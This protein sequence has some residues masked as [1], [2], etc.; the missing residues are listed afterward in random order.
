MNFHRRW[1]WWD[2]IQAIFLHLFYFK[3]IL[4]AIFLSFNFSFLGQNCIFYL[5]LALDGVQCFYQI[6]INFL[7]S[8]FQ[9]IESRGWFF[10]LSKTHLKLRHEH[11]ISMT[12]EQILN[13]NSAQLQRN[14][15]DL[16]LLFL[17]IFG[18]LEKLQSFEFVYS[19]KKI[20]YTL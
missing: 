12:F 14:K 6:L 13:P 19:F 15:L 7:C 3:R 11:F 16:S 10:F 9:E 8:H 20:K 1:R 4:K 2:W 17:T 18:D 5:F